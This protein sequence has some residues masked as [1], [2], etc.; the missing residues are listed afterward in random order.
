MKLFGKFSERGY[1]VEAFMPTSSRERNQWTIRVR[2]GKRMVRSVS[3][4]MLY[5]P[6]YGPDSGDVATLEEETAKLL[7]KLP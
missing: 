5:E 1:D 2:K 3:V 4:L 7:K 6:R